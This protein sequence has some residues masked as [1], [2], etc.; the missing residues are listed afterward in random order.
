MAEPLNWRRGWPAQFMDFHN[1]SKR[2]RITHKEPIGHRHHNHS[3][4]L[5]FFFSPDTVNQELTFS[6]VSNGKAR[7]GPDG[8]TWRWPVPRLFHTHVSLR[9]FQTCFCNSNCSAT[10]GSLQMFQKAASSLLSHLSQTLVH[11]ILLLAKS[12]ALAAT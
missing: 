5:F 4:S 9:L 8:K 6:P 12:T 3:Y 11:I 1:V 7:S 2:E 10:L